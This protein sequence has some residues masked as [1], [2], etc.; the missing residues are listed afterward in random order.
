[1]QIRL[2][3]QGAD[4]IT[5]RDRFHGFVRTLFLHRRKSLRAAIVSGWSK[6]FDKPAVD[7]IL[8]KASLAP[9]IRA[10]QLDVPARLRLS[11]VIAQATNGAG[12]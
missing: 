3:Q 11:D 1:M 6:T 4:R 7:Q 10:E 9:S 12:S 5:D 8:V 2:D